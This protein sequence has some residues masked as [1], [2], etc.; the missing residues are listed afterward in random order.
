MIE[1][2]P[3]QAEFVYSPKRV[4]GLIGGRGSGKSVGGGYL[5]ANRLTHGVNIVGVAPTYK[6]LEPILIRETLNILR[7]FGW[8]FKYNK[9]D[10]F[11]E[12]YKDGRVLADAYFRSCEDP[13]TIRGLTER[14]VLI[15]DEA[16]LCPPEAYDIGLGTLRGKNVKYA[17]TFLMSTPRGKGNW[18]SQLLE[19]PKS[20]LIQVGTSSN[21]HLSKDYVDMLRER[22]TDEF[23]RQEID[24][25]II[26]AT[27]CG[28]FPSAIVDSL[29]RNLPIEGDG[30]ITIGF[31]VAG[32]GDD[33]SVI[34]AR[35]GKRILHTIKRRTP[36]DGE[37]DAMFNEMVSQYPASRAYVDSTGMGHFVPSRLG[38]RY[39]DVEFV[40]VNFGAK[41]FDDEAFRNRRAEIYF[42]LK[43]H[44]TQG[45]TISGMS[46]E[47]RRL[48]AVELYSTEYYIDNSRCFALIPKDKIKKAIGRSP[49]I[50]D[51]LALSCANGSAITRAA[52]EQANKHL[53]QSVRAAPRR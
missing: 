33:Y 49:D 46:E 50:A 38:P 48:L 26:D 4:T 25:E 19:D 8:P 6:M 37:L 7:M 34:I 2:L 36:T 3:H 52:V 23:A 5:G 29:M 15:M 45:L 1:L 13:E 22:Y 11:L 42:E 31:D 27:A 10:K 53:Y 51:A 35:R 18:A 16:A 32:S 39:P 17:Q 20:R 40:G 41:A 12:V 9:T 24:G 21:S 43:R 47:D 44:C 30:A 14:A 28:L